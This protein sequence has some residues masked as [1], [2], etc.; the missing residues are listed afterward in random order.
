MQ[1]TSTQTRKTFWGDILVLKSAEMNKQQWQK[2]TD[3]HLLQPFKLKN[4][5]NFEKL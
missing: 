4:D 3:A 2:Y 5:G 1:T